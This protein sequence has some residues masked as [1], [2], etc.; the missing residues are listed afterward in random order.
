MPVLRGIDFAVPPG[1]SAA[2]VGASGCGKSTLLHLLGALD[3]PTRGEVRL[4]GERV[5]ELGE[6]RLAELRNR[7]V[8]FVFQFHHLLRD[9]TA[10]ENVMLPRMIAGASREEAADRAAELLGQVGLADR[11]SHRPRRLSGGEQQRVAVARALANEP[12]LVLADE[13]SGNLD[14]EATLRLHD[15]LFEMIDRH[16]ASL[17]VVTH[18]REL[19][20]RAARVLRLEGGELFPL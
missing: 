1:A 16:G 6:E 10:L 8:G 2:I 19:A 5:S 7:F 18:S 12:P 17:V 11:V 4:G 14:T 15:L 9:F 13:P 3:Q 20:G